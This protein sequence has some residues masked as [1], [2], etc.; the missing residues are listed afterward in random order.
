MLARST[1][2]FRL[3]D[4][5]KAACFYS[6]TSLGCALKERPKA[7]RGYWYMNAHFARLGREEVGGGGLARANPLRRPPDPPLESGARDQNFS[8]APNWNKDRSLSAPTN[9]Q[10]KCTRFKPLDSPIAAS[11]LRGTRSQLQLPSAAS[12]RAI[13]ISSEFSLEWTPRLRY[14]Q[15]PRSSKVQFYIFTSLK[16]CVK[17]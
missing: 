1:F 12:A 7:R 15:A 8:R 6:E 11:S 10:Y 17:A 4:C 13:K 5:L 3:S 2:W 16:K 14:Q 9:F